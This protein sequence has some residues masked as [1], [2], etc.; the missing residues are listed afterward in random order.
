MIQLLDKIDHAED[1]IL[2]PFEDG[3]VLFNEAEQS[4]FIL[5]ES[6]AFI[7]C[8]VF[9]VDSRDELVT[10][11][12]ERFS[13]S[14]ELARD[15]IEDFIQGL[16]TGYF[17]LVVEE[18]INSFLVVL[19]NI[20][21]LT[22]DSLS[23]PLCLSINQILYELYIDSS[24]IRD[25]VSR[26]YK[27]FVC[28]AD[29]SQLSL[30][31]SPAVI[32][33]LAEEN[34]FL[35][36]VNGDCVCSSLPVEG[37]VPYVFGVVF[38]ILWR[39][40][41]KSRDLMFHAATLSRQP[42]QVIMF[43][44]EPR[45]G[46]STLSAVL[47]DKGW[48]FFTDELTIVASQGMRALPCSLPVCVKDGSVDFLSQFYPQLNGLPRHRRLD[49]QWVRYLPVENKPA[50][51]ADNAADIEAIVFPQYDNGFGCEFKLLTKAEALKRLLAC[52]SSGRPLTYDEFLCVLRLV[53][54]T[55]CYSLR[56]S[57]ID[58]VIEVLGN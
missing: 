20:P 15:D 6:A 43:P 16:Q 45:A 35:I 52:G 47:A 37:V 26:L 21:E 39:S 23:E 51:A 33:V 12:A 19:E 54:Q 13:I 48:L 42:G 55:A 38:E 1:Y 8:A 22:G 53:E 3:C 34:E 58:Q 5:N 2:I 30:S 46:K 41:L 56:Y 50:L 11:L 49:E 14:S 29:F 27:H 24:L 28:A 10:L 31:C 57:D 36:Y 25:E 7:W 4:V 40:V 18:D 9:D 17:C 32:N 44:G